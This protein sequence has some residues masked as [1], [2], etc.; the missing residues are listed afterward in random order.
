[1]LFAACPTK[2][3]CWNL[4]G[5]GLLVECRGLK[6]VPD[7]IPDAANVID[8]SDNFMKEFD[9]SNNFD[10]CSNVKKLNLELAHIKS[11][12]QDLFQSMLE[13]ETIMLNGNSLK[14]DNISFPNNPFE[15][16]TS[17]K[18]VSL[19]SWVNLVTDLNAFGRILDMLPSTLEELNIN[20]P[21]VVGIADMIKKF[22][23]LRK[24]GLYDAFSRNLTIPS[25]TFTPLQRVP[26]EQLKMKPG[27][28]SYVHPLTFSPFPKLKTLDLSENKGMTIADLSPALSGLK[29]TNAGK[30]KLSSFTR[31]KLRPNLAILNSSFFN[32][33]AEIR[34]LVDLQMDMTE[35]YSHQRYWKTSLAIIQFTKVEYFLQL[36][37]YERHGLN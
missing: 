2:C 11:I 18:S 7:N 20:I 32:G 29:F 21:G 27:F 13:I 23:K 37:L 10:N 16:L 8:M 17:L 24:L 19:Q 35:I 12:P 25:G 14:Y 28:L 1:M 4:P 31:S 9:K 30:I 33:L 3:R 5:I 6:E 26:I 15:N 34:S 22:K 36:H